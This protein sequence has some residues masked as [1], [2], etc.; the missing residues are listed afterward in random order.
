MFKSKTPTI[1]SQ[2]FIVGFG[3]YHFH[4]QLFTQYEKLC[5]YILYS[6]SDFNHNG[7]SKNGGRL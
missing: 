2:G 1:K 3:S 5:N 7:R 4:R 6:F